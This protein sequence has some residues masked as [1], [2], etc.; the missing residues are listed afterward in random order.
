M[1]YCIYGIYIIIIGRPYWDQ[2]FNQMK[3]QR[4]HT[5]I[6]VC[7]CGSSIIGADLTEMCEKYRYILLLLLLYLY[8]IN[9]ILDIDLR[10]FNT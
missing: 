4:Q 3:E 8:F 5:D 1:I 2:I 6:G 10:I 7:F 9:R